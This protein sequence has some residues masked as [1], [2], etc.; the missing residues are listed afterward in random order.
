MKQDVQKRNQQRDRE[1]VEQRSKQVA[2]DR[3]RHAPGV[4]AQIG[5]KPSIDWRLHL[6]RVTVLGRLA[7]LMRCPPSLFPLPSSLY[8]RGVS[9][10]SGRI[11]SSG[12]T[13]PCRNDP[14]YRLWYSRSLVG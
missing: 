4:R 2:N 14:R 8:R 9:S 10:A 12:V 5:E 6:I 1:T 11:T 7:K 13:P 3:D